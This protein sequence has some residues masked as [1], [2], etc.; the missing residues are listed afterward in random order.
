LIIPLPLPV[1]RHILQ[2]DD[3]SDKTSNASPRS[4]STPRQTGKFK[5][6]T[7]L[8]LPLRSLDRCRV[9]IMVP[10]PNICAPNRSVASASNV[11]KPTD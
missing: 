2:Q 11:S 6:G 7:E 1:N 3:C 5:S 10:S 9:Q 4:A 8:S